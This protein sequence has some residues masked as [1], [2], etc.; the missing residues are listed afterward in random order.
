MSSSCR[1]VL[2]P[3]A[4]LVSASA[5]FVSMASAADQPNVTVTT[6]AEGEALAEGFEN[7]F[8][9]FQGGPLFLTYEKEGTVLRTI[10]GIRS[11]K[12][13]GAVLVIVTDKGNTLAIPA[14]RVLSLTDE[15]PPAF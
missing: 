11:V 5:P 13:A 10:S 14:R 4:L 1:R 7:A 3:L 12:A 6:P 2:L 9:R 15:R 8:E